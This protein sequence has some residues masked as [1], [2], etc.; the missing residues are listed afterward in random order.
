MIF[1]DADKLGFDAE[2]LARLPDFFRSYLDKGRLSGMSI[3]VA[4]DG[5][6][7]HLS[8]RGSSSLEDDGF[9]IDDSAIFRIY[10]MTKPITSVAIMTL[11]EQGLL[12]LHDPI[13]KFLPAFKNVKVFDSGTARDYTVRD[14]ERM[15]TVHD[16]LTHQSGLS[17]DFLFTHPVDAIY[18]NMKVNGARSEGFDLAGLTD[19]LAELPLVFSPGTA[20]NYSVATDVLGRIVEVI[21]GKTLDVFFQENIFDP[22]GMEDTSFTIADNKR[23]RLTHNY[24]RD[25]LKGTIELADSSARTIYAPGRKF[26]SGGG[27]LL[28]TLGDYYKFAD[29]VRRGGRLGD[30]RILG[31]KTIDQMTRNHLPDNKTL[32]D[33]AMGTFSEV[34]MGGTGFG[35]GF[36]VVIDPSQTPVQSSVRVHSWGGMASTFFW[37]D[38]VEDMIVILM[39]Q[40]MPAA[41]YPLRPQL[42]QMVYAA[43]D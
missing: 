28:S 10:S 29:M 14:P 42:Q 12:Q 16:L 34:H 1:E 22:L 2:R 5:K 24:S 6:V 33:C 36:S 9:E 13:T 41:S 23:H 27:G 30:A 26:L 8:H 40:M 43:L 35:L 19:K 31:R 4:R 11:Y 15:I 7:A 18:R 20:W 3:L 17:Y 25:P 32:R 39:T 37:I 38:P 21:S